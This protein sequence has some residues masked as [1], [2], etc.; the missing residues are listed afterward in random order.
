MT[1]DIN[2]EKLVLHGASPA[3]ST[4]VVAEERKPLVYAYVAVALPSSWAGGD[5]KVS[6]GSESVEYCQSN[7]SEFG[8]SAA[9]WH[10]ASISQRNGSMGS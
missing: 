5:L 8:M 7:N 9:T 6:L 1:T 4:F 3:A 2:L 10:G